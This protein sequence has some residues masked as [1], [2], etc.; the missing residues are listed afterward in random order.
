MAETIEKVK[1]NELPEAG[2]MASG[3]FVICVVDGKVQIFSFANLL[4]VFLTNTSTAGGTS[5]NFEDEES[6]VTASIFGHGTSEGWEFAFSGGVATV[7]VPALAFLQHVT[8]KAPAEAATYDAGNYVGALKL[9]IIQ[10]GEPLTLN[11]GFTTALLRRCFVYDA[12]NSEDISPETPLTLDPGLCI[13][14]ADEIEAG[15]LGIVFD[16]VADNY[17]GGVAFGF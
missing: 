4:Q 2:S 9:R 13:V 12:A 16:G 10:E 6:G 5:L 14:S 7:T 1:G 11:T 3:D 8:V 17:T 15:I